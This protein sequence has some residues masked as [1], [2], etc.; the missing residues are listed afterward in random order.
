MAEWRKI[1]KNIQNTSD[2]YLVAV[3]GGIDSM[4]LLDFMRNAGVSL[5]IVHFDHGIRDNSHLDLKLIQEYANVHAIVLHTTRSSSLTSVSDEADARAERWHFIERVAANR[6]ISH[7]ATAHH[8]DDQVENV[9][10]RLMRGDPHHALTM[11]TI[12]HVNGFIRYKPLLSVF[13]DEILE[14]AT[15]R[16]IKW[17][18]DSTNTDDRY[19]RNFIR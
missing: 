3:S 1:R 14:Q 9:F 4:F 2:C 7:I 17:N 6:N 5:E 11:Q 19:D 13:K 12:T 8:A 18:E 10:I 16:G 15:R